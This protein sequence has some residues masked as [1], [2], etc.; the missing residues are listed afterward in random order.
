M[1]GLMDQEENFVVRIEDLVV[2]GEGDDCRRVEDHTAV[3]AAAIQ[4]EPS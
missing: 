1:G 3:V 2:V 4:S